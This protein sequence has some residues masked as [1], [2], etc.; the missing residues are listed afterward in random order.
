MLNF[1]CPRCNLMICS[2]CLASHPNI[3]C[4][5]YQALPVFDRSLDDQAFLRLAKNQRYA[6]CGNCQ[7]YVERT[8]GCNNIHC[9]CGHQFCYACHAPTNSCICGSNQH[10]PIYR[11]A[12]HYQPVYGYQAPAHAPVHPPQAPPQSIPLPPAPVPVLVAGNPPVSGALEG[13]QGGDPLQGHRK[14]EAHRIDGTDE[15]ATTPCKT[16]QWRRVNSTMEV[17]R[18]DNCLE[19]KNCFQNKCDICGLRVC[20]TCRYRRI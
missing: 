5:Q 15:K 18:C 8:T 3:T 11:H 13:K 7:H 12:G 4:M 6:R 17:R 1:P 19:K 16:H 14:N 2:A 10:A 20:S 9:R